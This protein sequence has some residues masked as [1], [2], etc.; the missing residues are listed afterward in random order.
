MPFSIIVLLVV[1]LLI[2]VRGAGRVRLPIWLVMVGGALAV[3]VAGEIGLLDALRAINLDV[4]LFLFGVFVVGQ[5]LESSGYLFHLSYRLFNRARSADGLILLILFGMGGASAFLMND[6]LAIIGTPL[7]L[8]L[9]K[10]HRMAPQALLLALAFA[11]TLGSVLSPIGNP[12]N[13]LIALHGGFGNPFLDFVRYLALPTLIN[14]VIA[15]FLLKRFYRESF[16]GEALVH[17]RHELRD[18]A[19][20][21]LARFSLLLLVALVG[22]KIVLAFAGWG[23]ELRLTYIALIAAAPVLLFSAQRGQIL[24]HVDWYTL[25]FFAAMFV[26]MAAVWNSGFFQSWMA[27]WGGDLTTV[28]VVLTVGVLLSQLV[29]NVPLVALYLPMLQHAGASPEALIALAA[30]S[31]I[32]GNLLVLGAAS[33]VII[34]QNAEKKTGHSIGFLE[35]ARVGIPLTALNALVYWLFLTMF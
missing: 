26:L 6:T 27:R 35:F 10:Q 11:V 25:M 31:T 12:Q 24:R 2:S 3:L 34:I 9:A 19:L 23:A 4:M 8:L 13:L 5:A 18:P 33:N 30:G 16:H 28:P 14:L 20:V 15:F 7:V 21:R 17:V 29:S 32:A 1:F 22:I